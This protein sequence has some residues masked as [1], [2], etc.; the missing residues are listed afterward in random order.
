MDCDLRQIS[1]HYESRGKGRPFV[2][3]HE[4]PSDHYRAMAQVEP[5]FRGRSGWQRIYPDLPGHGR[6]SGAGR[7][8]DM[9]DYLDVMIEFADKVTRGG[10][11]SVGGSS[12]G[13]YLA[14]GI[15]RKRA[16][17]VEGVLLSVPEIN[18]RP[19]EDRRDEVFG[20]RPME[21]LL[22]PVPGLPE[23]TEDTA[24]LQGLPFRDVSFNL[25][26]GSESIRAPTLFLL[27]RQDAP[28]RYQACWKLLP[29][30]PQATFALL[31]RASHS[32]W[33]DRRE[34]VRGLVQ[35][36]LD[37]VEAS[38]RARSRAGLR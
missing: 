27:G 35:D 17:K 5:A 38:A 36:W 15:A 26:R 37:R 33:T 28:F 18:H 3:L 2:M 8:R 12:F 6:T 19:I 30:F 22:N 16:S 11:F 9:D 23:Y 29:D 21:E 31:D 10:R 1:I 13:A 24:W 20:S 7:I 32:L 14:L 25:Y 34:L 4:S